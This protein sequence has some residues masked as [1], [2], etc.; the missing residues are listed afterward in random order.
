MP[1]CVGLSCRFSGRAGRVEEVRVFSGTAGTCRATV[2]D[3]GALRGRL[4]AGVVAYVPRYG[5]YV[6]LSRAP[7]ETAL[8]PVHCCHSSLPGRY[9]SAAYTPVCGGTTDN[10]PRIR[11]GGFLECCDMLRG[12]PRRSSSVRCFGMVRNAS[13]RG[14]PPAVSHCPAMARHDIPGVRRYAPLCAGSGFPVWLVMV[15]FAGGRGCV[16]SRHLLLPV[17]EPGLIW[18]V[19]SRGS[20]SGNTGPSHNVALC[21]AMARAGGSLGCSAMFRLTGSGGPGR[22]SSGTAA[23]SAA[24]ASHCFAS[25]GIFFRE[26]GRLPGAGARI[27]AG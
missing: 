9:A 4:G 3:P 23:G 7:R 19:F 10:M 22:I 27:R 11:A 2:R 21:R 17:E 16:A 18:R 26:P 5:A 24:L 1:Q 6:T 13:L 15:R 14:D 25:G 12:R 20:R 8:F